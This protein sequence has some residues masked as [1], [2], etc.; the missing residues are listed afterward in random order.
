MTLKVLPYVYKITNIHTNQ[1]YIGSRTSKNQ[2]HHSE[3]LGFKYF[4]S[5]N[6]V[7]ELGFENFKIDWI[8]EFQD[9]ETAYK[10]EQLIIF[11][12]FKDPLCLNKVCH[13]GKT[14]FSMSDKIHSQETRLKMSKSQKGKIVS[15]DHKLKISEANK[16]K[17]RSEETKLKISKTKKGKIVSEETKLKLSKPRSEETKFKMSK[18]KSEETKF[19]ISEARKGK[20]FI[21]NGIKNL[22]V[23]ADENFIMPIGYKFGYSRI[24]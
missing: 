15:V 5:S 8:E 19:K 21:T 6:Y 7:K 23:F 9:S 16:G 2:K 14:N 17:T 13:F 11:E 20:K 12:S 10:F 4:T 3:D 24:N 1:F 18:P 22:M